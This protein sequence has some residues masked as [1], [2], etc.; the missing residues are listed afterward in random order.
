MILFSALTIAIVSVASTIASVRNAFAP[1]RKVLALLATPI[2][3]L[4]S[5]LVPRDD[6]LWLFMA[7]QGD[8]FADNSKY[9]FLYCD[10]QPDVRNV[11]IGTDERIVAELRE[12][13]YEA[14]TRHSLAGRW[15]LLRAGYWFETHG[16]IAPA[17]AGRA[18]LIHLTHGNYLKVMLE[19]H[20]RDW[21]WIVQVL[22]EFFFERRRR[23]VVTGSGPPLKNMQSMRGAPAD[24]AL[25]TGLPRNDALFDAFQ[26]EELGLEESA[27]AA[28][29]DRAAEGPVLLYAPTY[30]EGYGERNGV[31]LSELDLGLERLDSVLRSHDATLYI[32][33]HPAT[34][35]DRDLEGLDRVTVLE[36]GGDLYPFLR[37]CD[38]LVTDYSGIFYDFLLLDRPMV[39]FAPDLE[40]YLEDRDLYFDYEDHVPGTIATTPEAFVESVRAILE[41]ADEHGDDRAAVREA[42]YDDPDGEACERV[43]HTVRDEA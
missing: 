33:H 18:R 38:V 27:L 22:V 7:G 3:F 39:F 43:Y 42:F 12:H 19:D 17:Y 21:P 23:Y 15:R 6:S 14:Y 34:T 11:W 13:G 16:P 2:V 1:I 5:Y 37:E 30:R 35:F 28:V 32:S 4:V 40:V 26:D 36:S 25:M 29:R 10:C 9:L 8:R 31:P 24:R 41:G 20:T